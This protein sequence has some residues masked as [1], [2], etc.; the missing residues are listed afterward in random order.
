MTSLFIT[1]TGTGI[2]KTL[3][4]AGLVYRARRAGLDALALKPV[5]SGYDPEDEESD[6]AL[7]LKAQGLAPSDAGRISPFAFKAPLSPD[8][9]ARREGRGIDPDALLRFC[10]EAL[11]SGRPTLIE[12]VGGA[13]VP[14]SS[15][16]LVADWIAALDLPFLLLAGGYLGTISHT[17]ATLEAL[18]AR[19]L[20]PSALILS[21]R[22]D[23]PVPLEETAS[24]LAIAKDMPVLLMPAL[25]GPDAWRHLPDL[26]GLPAPW[27]GKN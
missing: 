17:L 14:L 8:M 18:A 1:A 19:G 5:I 23:D 7:L 6:T 26:A 22:P 20:R 2:G 3:L 21:G 16:F 11:E 13:F 15:G 9:A 27:G 25:P 10:R 12:G 4:S 24:S